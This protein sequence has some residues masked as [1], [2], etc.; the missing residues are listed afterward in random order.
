[1]ARSKWVMSRHWKGDCVLGC[2]QGLRM[3]RRD[4]VVLG[5]PQGAI[6]AP[7]T[8]GAGEG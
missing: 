7:G 2:V 8:E 5:A 3:L 1:M 4:D 6:T